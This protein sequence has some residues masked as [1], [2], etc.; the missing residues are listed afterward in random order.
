MS[1]ADCGELRLDAGGRIASC[2]AVAAQ[3]LGA[4][5]PEVA[6]GQSL[7]SW[8]VPEAR[9]WL[10]PSPIGGYIGLEERLVSTL[11]GRRLRVT[12][13]ESRVTLRDETLLDLLRSEQQG[14]L[15]DAA[16]LDIIPLL[17]RELND[18]MSIVLGRLELLIE[19]G[20]AGNPAVDRHLQVALEHAR[21]VSNTLHLLRM[22]GRSPPSCSPS[23]N[24][25][26]AVQAALS[27]LDGALPVQ[28]IDVPAL[29]I[30]G[31]REALVQGL[32]ALVLRLSDRAAP[33]SRLVVRAEERAGRI[34]LELM[35]DVVSDKQELDWPARDDPRS[36]LGIAGR[37]FERFGI[38]AER[39]R[40]GTGMCFR[41]HFARAG[42]IAEV[43]AGPRPVVWLVGIEDPAE[44]LARALGRGGCRVMVLAD[45]EE[46]LRQLP[47]RPPDG[48][49][50]ALSLGGRSGLALL[51]AVAEVLPELLP[52][53]AIVA[54][55]S[56]TG[57]PP[58]VKIL[59]PPVEPEAVLRSMGFLRG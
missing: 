38:D 45:A 29:L 57:L 50:C 2:C 37:A 47:E 19:L 55:S 51:R 27:E 6:V 39:C 28:E 8:F 43:N 54:R 11:G 53:C 56:V 20:G 16:L 44:L 22:V 40:L 3:L 58:A 25:A 17:R 34:V 33:A 1:P 41:L 21:R 13:D 15:A 30:A 35:I 18:P 52:R 46:A 9:A 24:L 7:D 49:L 42:T 23:V 59:R 12:F 48:M 10:V 26:D 32:V 4:G 14:Q 5:R 31:D 36:E